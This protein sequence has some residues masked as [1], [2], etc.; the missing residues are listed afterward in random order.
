[1]DPWSY[2]TKNAYSDKSAT[3]K[4]TAKC[5][6]C[7]QAPWVKVLLTQDEERWSWIDSRVPG[8]RVW[9]LS[10]LHSSSAGYNRTLS[11]LEMG[12]LGELL[13]RA[14]EHRWIL[15]VPGCLTKYMQLWC[16]FARWYSGSIEKLYWSSQSRQRVQG[17]MGCR[18]RR[19]GDFDFIILMGTGLRLVRR[20]ILRKT[21]RS[22]RHRRMQVSLFPLDVP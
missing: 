3:R 16:A 15:C 22:C 11:H 5:I 18:S 12:L 19:P 6:D 13:V 20:H 4:V 14:Q 7:T 10:K 1:M 9:Y 17:V 2:A 21:L 8:E